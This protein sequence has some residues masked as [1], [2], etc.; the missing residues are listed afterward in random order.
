VR[1]SVELFMNGISII[2]I[3]ENSHVIWNVLLISVVLTTW[4]SWHLIRSRNQLL[5]PSNM[6]F[7]ICEYSRIIVIILLVFWNL[8]L[9]LQNH[10]SLVSEV[11]P[12]TWHG[13]AKSCS[14]HFIIT[15]VCARGGPVDLTSLTHVKSE[16]VVSEFWASG[17]VSSRFHKFSF[18]GVKCCS[19]Q[20]NL[21]FLLLVGL[22]QVENPV[23]VHVTDSIVILTWFWMLFPSIQIF[24]WL[25]ETLVM[26]LMNRRFD[27]KNILSSFVPLHQRSSSSRACNSNSIFWLLWFYFIW[28]LA[29]IVKFIQ[30]C[31]WFPVWNFGSCHFVVTL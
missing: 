30:R 18:V 14:F 24:I 5:L 11:P 19:S 10:L 3:V 6:I 22:S 17:L 16:I 2:W 29:K 27:F 21:C 9:L 13:A 1:I 31:A 26:R 28:V 7:D 20:W 4:L 12:L 8:K 25:I 23:R 15:F